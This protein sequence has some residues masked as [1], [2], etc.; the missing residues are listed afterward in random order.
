VLGALA[1]AVVVASASGSTGSWRVLAPAPIRPT[2]GLGSVWTGKEMLLFGRV[3]KTTATGEVKGRFL[4]SAAYDP[5]SNGWRKLSPPAATSGFLGLSTVWTGKE[6]LAWGQGTR[7]A[8]SPATNRW[9][10]LPGSKLLAIHDGFGLV[11]WTGKELIGWGG[12][13]CGDAF[14]DGVAY[15]PATNRWRALPRSPLA[16]SQHPLGAWTGK[17]LIV[18]VGN[19]DPNGTPWPA[20]LARAAAY[21]PATS[22]WRRIASLPPASSPGAAVWDGHELLVV[23]GTAAGRAGSPPTLTRTGFAYNPATNRWRTLPPMESGRA[24]AAA[25]WTGTRLLLWGGRTGSLGAAKPTIPPH[26]FAY[27]PAANRWS[28]LPA[29]PILG[30]LDPTATWT[31]RSLIVWGGRTGVGNATR[32]DGAAFT[33]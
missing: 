25:V 3:T 33:P 29:A 14:D 5:S 32:S 11:V 7:V 2:D 13:C 8:Y 15:D 27:D 31:G 22:T 16:G 24:N 28:A 4:V 12:G 21:N 19:L 10:R 1:A 26:G 17:E 23:G 9:R 6:L 20:R 18:L 30:R